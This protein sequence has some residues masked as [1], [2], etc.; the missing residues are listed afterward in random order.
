MFNIGDLVGDRY[1]ILDEARAGG[2]AFVFPAL[3]TQTGQKV[4]LKTLQQIRRDDGESIK[5]FRREA[6]VHS[7]LNHPHIV[8]MLGTEVVD[9]GKNHS[10][11]MLVFEWIKGG[12]TLESLLVS[13]L[14]KRDQAMARGEISGLPGPCIPLSVILRLMAQVAL[15]IDYAHGQGFI[16]RD[17]KPSNIL[18]H[19]GDDGQL[20]AK[21][22][23]FGTAKSQEIIA[24]LGPK[25]TS[26]GSTM[27]TPLYMSPEQGRGIFGRGNDIYSFWVI[28][29]EAMTGTVPFKVGLP[30][31]GP[32]WLR[33]AAGEETYKPIDELCQGVPE[34]LKLLVA[35]GLDKDPDRR[36][37]MKDSALFLGLMAKENE[38][39][40]MA[41]TALRMLVPSVYPPRH[42]PQEVTLDPTGMTMH[43]TQQPTPQNLKPVSVR[44]NGHAKAEK[45][46]VTAKIST[47]PAQ[48]VPAT[49]AKVFK[50]AQVRQA[51]ES[52]PASKPATVLSQSQSLPIQPVKETASRPIIP[53]VYAAPVIVEAPA[54]ISQGPIIQLQPPVATSRWSQ[55]LPVMA[56]VVILAALGWATSQH[57]LPFIRSDARMGQAPSGVPE[58]TSQPMPVVATSRPAS[59]YVVPIA[60]THPTAHLPTVPA[61]P[62]RAKGRTPRTGGVATEGTVEGLPPG[63]TPPIENP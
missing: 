49:Q 42:D 60:S 10:M 3:D 45:K 44:V 50:K 53:V 23:D 17:I 33:I 26:T 46:A 16:H 27:G 43:Q 2:M 56:A 25:L 11:M 13:Y 57:W 24:M 1:R 4:A 58:P 5:R 28:M 31:W 22:A 63:A 29:Y 6:L 9:F 34:D 47:K 32:L 36:I 48:V 40:A 15:A 12:N 30:D 39:P 55:V 61:K 54:P 19:Q 51:M 41:E 35:R 8:R 14:E 21:V 52:Q 18:L 20:V 38:D 37:S 59:T 62:P 7:M